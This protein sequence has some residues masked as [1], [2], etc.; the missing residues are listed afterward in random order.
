MAPALGWARIW[1][2]PP[3]RQPGIGTKPPVLAQGAQRDSHILLAQGLLQFPRG[4]QG[5]ARTEIH[6]ES[7]P[8]LG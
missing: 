7:Q 5:E 4:L 3:H 8:H 6:S 1:I 2:S